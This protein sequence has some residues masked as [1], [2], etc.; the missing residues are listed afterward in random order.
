VLLLTAALFYD[1]Q[2]A[3]AEE[4]SDRARD[5]SVPANESTPSPTVEASSQPV[6]DPPMP[7]DEQQ[8]IRAVQDARTAFQQAP[9]EMAQGGTRA[10]RREAICRVLST[11]TVSGW[12][13]HISKLGSNSDGKGVL[14]I[15]LAEG[16]LI[17]TWNDDLS[18]ISDNTLIDPSSPLFHDLSQMKVGD[19]VFFSG[20]FLPSALDCVQE[21][22]LTLSGSMT[23]PEFVFRFMNVVQRQ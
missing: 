23:D 2:P 11:P 1:N 3:P 5:A 6:P 7:G 4:S 9:N 13:G 14:E 10:Q 19:E 22:S 17:K 12:I 15:S 20:L 8:F 16:L 18:D 21:A